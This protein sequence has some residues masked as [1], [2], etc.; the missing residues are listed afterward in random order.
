MMVLKQL[1]KDK[2]N[3]VLLYRNGMLQ[4][5]IAEMYKT[6][7]TSIARVLR[8]EGV[9]NRIVISE[10]DEY[11][12][13]AAYQ[14]GMTVR[15]IAKQ[16]NIGKKRASDI[17]KKHDVKIL[18]S[19]DRPSKYY[20]NEQYFDNIDTQDKAYILGFL[21]ADGCNCVNNISICLQERDKDILD[22]INSAI[23][24]NR[25]LRFIDYSNR[26]G[27]CQNQYN[28]TVTNKYMSNRL[29]ELGMVQNKS[30]IL[31]FPKWIDVSLYPHFIRGYF[32]G[33]GYVSKNYYNAKL[34][35]VSTNSFCES[36][37]TILREYV[38]INSSIYLC[39]KNELT[40]TRTLQISGRNQ[41]Q[42]FLDYIYNDANL[43]LQR[44]Y[45]IYQSLYVNEENI[46]N[47]LT[48]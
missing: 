40:T 10:E 26:D 35:I 22:K 44:K 32:D 23:G 4:K 30:L 33:D 37:Q 3:I 6:S 2:D 29:I 39:H 14:N 11:E 16:F 1:M 34:S 19:K 9:V 8:S 7:T 12:M 20:I 38:G 31:E 27:N 41:I 45:N 15:D 47:T 25:P 48:A 13:I 46:N 5:E 21:Y 43:Y 18:L 28:L 17:L 24:S 42:K 36:I